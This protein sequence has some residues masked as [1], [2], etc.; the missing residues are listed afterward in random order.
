MKSYVVKRILLIIPTIFLISVIIFGLIRAVPGNVVDMMTAQLGSYRQIDREEIEQKLGL[1]Q[2]VYKQ[3][4]RWLGVVPD[5]DGELNGILQG[6]FGESLWTST[7]V[8]DEIKDRL[9]VTLELGIIALLI[10]HLIA[11]PLGVYSA[12]RRE[13]PGDL[14]ARSF[15]V[16]SIA[17]PDF[18]LA[19]MLIIFPALWWGHMASLRWIPFFES[20][21]ENL[22]IVLLPSFI[23]GLSM[24]GTTTRLMRNRMIDVLGRDYIRTAWAKGLNGW[25][26]IMRHALKNALIPVITMTGI[27]VASIFG[28][29]VIIEKIFS[30]PGMG[31]LI[32][33]AITNRDYPVVSG[34]LFFTAIFVMAV[35]LIV[36]LSYA[37]LDPRVRYEKGASV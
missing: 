17:I 23:L 35:S 1:D 36:D 33:D 30:I 11:I 34:V 26:V 28:G 15:S 14:I 31:R 12:L 8:M 22:K 37:L 32:T 5:E 10:A 3:Y 19:T 16:L 21:I 18:W 4:G 2:P 27:Q 6:N 13:T 9:P 25:L 24:S 7:T 20:P 29:A